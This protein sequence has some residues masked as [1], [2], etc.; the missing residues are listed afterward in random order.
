MNA[1]TWTC[2]CLWA[3]LAWGCATTQPATGSILI[4]ESGSYGCGAEDGLGCGLELAPMLADLDQ[5]PGV[6]HSSASWDGRYVRLELA[7]DAN[8]E[9]VV[10]AA[11][12]RMHG[13]ARPLDPSRVPTAARPGWWDAA[14][15]IELSRY[16]AGV[17]ARDYANEI[18]AVASLADEERERIHG[19]LHKLLLDAFED[20]HA[21]GGGLHRLHDA[22]VRRRAGFE[23]GLTYLS[24]DQRTRI[25]QLIDEHLGG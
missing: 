11:A 25:G 17:L 18:A 2:V 19:A 1:T 9:H 21:Q 24:S 23:D 22:V 14:S 5:V 4:L 8:R 20:A 13:D 6:E 15:T 7:S 10:D 16:E 12:Q 3:F